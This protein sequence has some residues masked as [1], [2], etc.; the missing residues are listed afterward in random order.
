MPVEHFIEIIPMK[1]VDA[2]S[3]HSA[4]VE[5]FWGKSIQLN[6]IIGMGFDGASTFSGSRT[7]VQTRLKMQSPHAIFV[8]C[9]CHLL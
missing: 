8:H 1:K 9:P 3:I 7:G 4:L 2:E 6:C 5:C